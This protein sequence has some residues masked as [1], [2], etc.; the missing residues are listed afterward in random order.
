MKKRFCPG[1]AFRCSQP[2]EA[3]RVSPLPKA[4]AA[5]LSN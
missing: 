3:L 2:L 5:V 4:G 1:C